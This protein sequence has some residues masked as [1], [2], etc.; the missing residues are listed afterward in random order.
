MTGN[1][2]A[3]LQTVCAFLLKIHHFTL[4]ALGKICILFMKNMA[5]IT[6]IYLWYIMNLYKMKYFAFN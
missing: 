2:I 1:R 6:T 4:P 5:L 3:N